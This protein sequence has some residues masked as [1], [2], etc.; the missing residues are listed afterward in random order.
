[1]RYRPSH[2]LEYVLLRLIIAPLQLLPARLALLWGWWHAAL[3]FHVFRFR[4]AETVRRIEGVFG[5][6]YTRRQARRIAWQSW[7][8]MVFNA[9]ELM[10]LRPDSPHPRIPE[11]EMQEAARMARDHAATGRGAVFACPHMGNWELAGILIPR[12]G[13]PFMT[14]A[15]RLKNPLVN[16]YLMRLR[17]AGSIEIIE[18]GSSAV[19]HIMAKLKRGSIL[20]VLPDARSRHPGV[21]VAFL[22]GT[23]NVYPGMA[24]LARKAGVPIYM[25]IMRRTAWGRHQLEACGPFEP[26]PNLSKDEDIKRLTQLVFDRIDAAVRADPGQ[27]FWFNRRWILDPLEPAPAA[28]PETGRG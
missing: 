27:W 21:T 14:V 23:A 12:I 16:R 13:L 3:A 9:V 24:A 8:N 25:G 7:L 22:G 11:V 5:D 19:R 10:R 1:M 15:A 4:V 2:I 18:Q 17:S 26:D 28:A 6:R 20:A